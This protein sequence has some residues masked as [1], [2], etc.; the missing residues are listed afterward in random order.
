MKRLVLSLSVMLLLVMS[1]SV[2]ASLIGDSIH[3][4]LSPLPPADVTV[5]DPGAE[6]DEVGLITSGPFIGTPFFQA[7]IDVFASSFTFA[8][9]NIINN[10]PID[11]SNIGAELSKL[12]WVDDPINGIITN[13][14]L[15]TPETSNGLTIL[16]LMSSD[17]FGIDSGS[18]SFGFAGTIPGAATASW[19]FDITANHPIPEPSTYLLFAVGILGTLGLGYHRRR[20]AA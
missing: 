1:H 8:L 19:S 9:R 10:V 14:S 16:N 2:S 13:V 6:F 7:T 11:F 20:K 4:E 18:I 5:V 15:T 17:G 12:D 3:I